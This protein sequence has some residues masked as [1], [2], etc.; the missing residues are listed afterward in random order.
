M[1]IRISNTILTVVL[2]IVGAMAAS[3]RSDAA[4]DIFMGVAHSQQSRVAASYARPSVVPEPARAEIRGRV[5][6]VADGDTITVL[7]ASNT[8]HKIRFYGID[9]PE[10][11]QAFGQKSKQQL[12]NYVFGKD[13][14]VKWKF[15]DK[16]GRVLGTV[17]VGG[18]DINLQMVRD[19]YAHHYKRFDNNP[20]YAAAEADARQMRRGL[21]SDPNPISPEDYR[22]RGTSATP[23]DWEKRRPAASEQMETRH[24]A[25]SSQAT[26]L[27][28]PSSRAEYR[29][30]NAMPVSSRTAVP[31]NDTYSETGFWLSTNSNKRHNRSCENY[32]KTRGYPCSKSEGTPCGKCGG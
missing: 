28:P 24:P 21:W 23:A 13:V 7:D 8:Q 30:G 27:P 18:K 19:G 17:F 5:V 10:K 20:V 22:H 31:V 12:S 6:K 2:A 3:F 11:S 26:N 29:A 15:K 32:R 4:P 25:A 16:Y 9:A 1:T 14:I